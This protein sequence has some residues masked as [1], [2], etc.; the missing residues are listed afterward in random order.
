MVVTCDSL[1]KRSAGAEGHR[2]ASRPKR[3]DGGS[4]ALAHRRMPAALRWSRR[5]RTSSAQRAADL[6]HRVELREVV[7]VELQ[8]DR[9]EILLK[10]RN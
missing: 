8:V 5:L 10:V 7:R 3:R 4:G 9:G 1:F 2:P 6:F